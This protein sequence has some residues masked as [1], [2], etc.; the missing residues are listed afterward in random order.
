MI[1]HDRGPDSRLGSIAEKIAVAIDKASPKKIQ[2]GVAEHAGPGEFFERQQQVVESRILRPV[3]RLNPR[4]SVVMR[5][6]LKPLVKD[7]MELQ[8]VGTGLRSGEMFRKI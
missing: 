3:H 7:T 2:R 8:H 6:G 1:V 5:H 4:R